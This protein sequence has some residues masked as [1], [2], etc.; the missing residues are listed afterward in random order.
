MWRFA[1]T[2]PGT[3]QKRI[4]AALDIGCTLFDTADIYGYSTP[5]GFGGAELLF[6]RVLR[7]A[8]ELRQGMLLATKGGIFPPLPYDSSASYLTQS[9]EKSLERLVVDCIDLYQIHRPTLLNHP[10]E[11]A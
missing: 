5:D 1:G 10:H 11:I 8:P 2:D 6:G 7:A 3:A 9:C 4:E